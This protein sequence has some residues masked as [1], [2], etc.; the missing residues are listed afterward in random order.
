MMSESRKN[1]AL[2][3][4]KGDF[5]YSKEEKEVRQKMEQQNIEIQLLRNQLRNIR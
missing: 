3:S 4:Q 5:W 2:H 1:A